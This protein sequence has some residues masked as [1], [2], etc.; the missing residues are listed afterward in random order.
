MS[1]HGA[2]RFIVTASPQPIVYTPSGISI[3]NVDQHALLIIKKLQEAG[4][5]AYLVG[6]SVRDLL[7]KQPPKD[8]DV[9][10]N[11]TPR[12][13]KSL[14]KRALIIGKRFLLVHI[15]F[16]KR[17]VVEVST[18]RAENS[19]KSIILQ[20]NKF[21]TEKEDAVRRDFTINGLFYDPY[22]DTI[23]DY[24]GGYSDIQ[25]QILRVIGSPEKSFYQDPVRMIRLLK[26][27][28]RFNLEIE[29][30]TLQA[31]ASCKKE[32]LKSSQARIFEEILR[33][34]ESGHATKFLKKHV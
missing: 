30:N 34:L 26:F 29:K 13:I 19:N 9:V 27:R 7:L 17:K 3:G 28:S 4:F 14:F 32:I 25:K 23:I 2:I 16:G 1:L 11:A 18:F 21:G 22:T 24:V 12:Q 20:D 5:S 8:F 6:G 33:M 15:I 10:T 31:L